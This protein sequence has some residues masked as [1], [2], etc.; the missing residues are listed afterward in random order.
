MPR[1]QRKNSDGRA[2][3]NANLKPFEKGQSGNPN[4]RPEGVKNRATVL[5]ELLAMVCDFSNP[6]TFQKETADL[7]TQIALALIARAR[8]GDVTAIREVQ[9]TLYGKLTDK[10]QINVHE[11]DADIERELALL[12]AGGQADSAGEA[13][14]ETAG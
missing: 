13:E 2:K 12:A 9:D 7:E 11:L 8:R 1:K 6:V 14:G 10:V 5:K 3:S 4:G